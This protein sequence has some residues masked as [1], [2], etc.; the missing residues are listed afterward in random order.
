MGGPEKEREVVRRKKWKGEREADD[1]ICVCMCVCEYVCRPVTR[2]GSIEPSSFLL[3]LAATRLLHDY[4]ITVNKPQL[5][6]A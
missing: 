4:C 3:L 2:A 1:K 6:C 5:L